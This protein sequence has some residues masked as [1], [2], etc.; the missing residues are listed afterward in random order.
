[1]VLYTTGIV[2]CKILKVESLMDL[3]TSQYGAVIAAL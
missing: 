1:M 2:K 3:D